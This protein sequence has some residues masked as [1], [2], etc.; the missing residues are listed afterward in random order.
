M[1][2]TTV[3]K[4]QANA[5]MLNENYL[6][7]LSA[8]R[9][10]PFGESV[11]IGEQM[12]TRTPWEEFP[13]SYADFGE[14]SRTDSSGLAQDIEKALQKVRAEAQE[15]RRLDPELDTI[16]ETA[17]NDVA[18]FF[19]AIYKSDYGKFDQIIPLPDIMPLD[20]GEIGL[21]W[22]KGQK[23]FTLSF[24]GDGHI[25]FAGIFSD[26]SRVRG[27]LTFSSPHLVAISSMIASI[28][29]YYAY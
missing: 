27:I 23:I 14:H 3:V 2:P 24:G 6:V 21:E 17:Y 11:P 5:P 25:V 4:H 12:K 16:P 20:D 15:E 18:G 1:N 10:R 7:G 26:E 19:K 8:N 9:N 29:R 28:Y 22:R 13:F